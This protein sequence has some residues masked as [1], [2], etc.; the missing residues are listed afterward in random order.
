LLAYNAD[1][2]A[3]HH[4]GQL[5]MA[6]RWAQGQKQ[7]CNGKSGGERADRQNTVS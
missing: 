7:A 3:L 1:N 2:R 5:H 6:V 4:L